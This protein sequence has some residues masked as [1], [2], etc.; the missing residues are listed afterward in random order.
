MT[1]DPP[2]QADEDEYQL[3]APPDPATLTEP[4]FG[5]F[6]ELAKVRKHVAPPRPKSTFFSGVFEFPWLPSVIL[7]WAFI[8]AGFTVVILLGAVAVAVAGQMSG[9]FGGAMAFFALPLFWLLLWVSSY[10]GACALQVLE[11]T[12]AGNSSEIDWPEPNW[13]EW[14]A[15]LIYLG[16][17]FSVAAVVAYALAKLLN[18]IG[19]PVEW[20]M[21]VFI[22]FLYPI[23]LLSAFYENSMWAVFSPALCLRLIRLAHETAL[24]Y[25]LTLAVWAVVGLISLIALRVSVFGALLVGPAIAAGVLITPRLMGRL[26]WRLQDAPGKVKSKTT[27]LKGAGPKDADSDGPD[28]D[29][30]SAQ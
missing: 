8:S 1:D 3:Q 21:P 2:D 16:F 17:L 26:L 13:R 18:F 23:V 27:M 12:A 24:F 25:A 30:P 22:V 11:S 9:P 20:S 14:A 5:V 29:D 15:K 28:V 19:L 10:A 4:T 7:R 6:D